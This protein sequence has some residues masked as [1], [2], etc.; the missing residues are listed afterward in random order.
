MSFSYLVIAKDQYGSENLGV[1]DTL[2]D[3]IKAIDLMDP[4][5]SGLTYQVGNRILQIKTVPHG[6][7][8]KTARELNYNLY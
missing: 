2:K 7:L 5:F 3:A 1:F 4:T 8:N 6:R